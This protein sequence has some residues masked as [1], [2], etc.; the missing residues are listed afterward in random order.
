MH[1]DFITIAIHSGLS[2]G[3]VFVDLLSLWLPRF[4][5]YSELEIDLK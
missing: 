3:K 5:T 2:L 1:L 4:T